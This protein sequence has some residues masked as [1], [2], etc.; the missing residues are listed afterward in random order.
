MP[1]LPFNKHAKPKPFVWGVATAA[2]QIEG[3][4][5]ED[6]RGPS[7]WDVHSKN[8]KT[9]EGHTGDVACDHYHRYEGDLDLMK[10][11]G[12]DAYRLSVSWPRVLPEGT[13]R[14]NGKGID[15]YNKLIDATLERGIDPWVTL[16]H[17]DMPLELER[18]GGFRNRDMVEWFGDYADLMGR[19]FGDRV[20][21]W[22]TINEPP[23]IIGHGL[24]EGIFAPAQKLP[25]AECLN[26]A[27][28]LLMAHG[29]GVQALRASV[30]DK[31]QIAITN[32][33]RER[34]PVSLKPKDIEAAR[35]DYFACEKKDFWNLAFWAD[36][37]MLGHYPK[38]AVR[39]F[40]ADMP[41]IR[42]GDMELIHQ[43][44]DFIGYNIYGGWRVRA[45]KD[46]KPEMDPTENKIGD[47]RAAAPWLA[48]RP[49]A[50]Y[51]AAKFQTE[52]YGKPIA[53]TENGMCNVDFVHRDG[54]V[55]DPQRKDFIDGY[56]HSVRQ[57]V[58]ENI[59]VKGYF[60]WSFMDN[61]EWNDGYEKRFGLVHVDFQTQERKPKDSF[62]HY[63]KIIR[64]NGS[65]L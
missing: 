56:L 34:I 44:T 5:N 28:N 46:G 2:Y 33:A 63:K 21:N 65:T 11:L 37:V 48:I 40:G 31:A 62:A 27:H 16:Y 12:V 7:I 35:K 13:G 61:Y 22:I 4:A 9:F 42:Q 51:W 10:Q 29:R 6:G 32:T 30:G 60:H 54:K 26:A 19:K 15:F 50:P 47:A 64:T 3:A 58:S 38:D 20:N 49:D 8:G 59:P 55:H 36:P 45:G 43:P 14:Q 17:W 52:R 1:I 24:Q 23:C 57:A 41:K 53:F 39:N 18:K 25:F